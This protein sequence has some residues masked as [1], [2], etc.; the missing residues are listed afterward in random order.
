[1][2]GRKSRTLA[3]R[4]PELLID[5]IIADRFAKIDWNF[6]LQWLLANSAILTAVLMTAIIIARNT[7]NS[8]T[9]AFSINSVF[10]SLVGL[11]QWF[12]L[13]RRVLTGWALSTALGWVCASSI[14]LGNWL[15]FG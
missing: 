4:L 6:W 12:V 11:V 7:E 1:M 10:G 2:L 15:E 9:I 3:V 8:Q 14:F 5:Q 13:R